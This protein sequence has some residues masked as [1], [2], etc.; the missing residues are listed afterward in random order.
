M[1]EKE[2]AR[3]PL[4]PPYLTCDDAATTEN[5]AKVPVNADTE[6]VENADRGGGP[7]RRESVTK[8]IENMLMEKRLTA[9]TST[10]ST[11][12]SSSIIVPHSPTQVTQVQHSV[13]SNNFKAS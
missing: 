13:K 6:E 11:N 9:T 1:D 4:P 5:G 7:L 12:N 10:T 3:S 2:K 8:Y